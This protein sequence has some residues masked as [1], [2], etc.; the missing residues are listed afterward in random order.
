MSQVAAKLKY[1][2]RK[3][4]ASELDVPREN[5]NDRR[6]PPIEV[7]TRLGEILPT[8]ADSVIDSK[9]P[10]Q[11]VHFFGDEWATLQGSYDTLYKALVMV[12][13]TGDI[14]RRVLRQGIEAVEIMLDG[15][16][17][18]EETARSGL[19]SSDK[20]IHV[21]SLYRA[22]LSLSCDRVALEMLRSGLSEIEQVIVSRPPLPGM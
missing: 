9:F 11:M 4:L 16:Q 20:R 18:N 6:G 8:L 21:P 1:L 22:Y 10:E 2:Q 14:D 12:E 13:R 15:V 3:L 5:P 19:S 17:A 7:P